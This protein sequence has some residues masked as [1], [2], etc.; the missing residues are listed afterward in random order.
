MRNLPG[1][2]VSRIVEVEDRVRNE[3]VKL[4]SENI[5]DS[6]CYCDARDLNT[7][8]SS[9]T[10][11]NTEDCVDSIH[12]RP[13]TKSHTKL[14]GEHIP[15]RV[16]IRND[17]ADTQSAGDFRRVETRRVK[18]FCVL[19]L[20]SRVNTD[21]LKTVLEQKRPHVR[22]M[23]VCPLRKNPRKVLLKLTLTANDQ[24]GFVL[25]NN[26]CPDYVKCKPWMPRDAQRNHPST[27]ATRWVAL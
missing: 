1:S 13:N 2:L 26:F 27:R 24:A 3:E 21:I 18:R 4:E 22:S 7:P 5:N 25:T 14:T 16:T 11:T 15:V 6:N 17:D 23:R 12:K 20:S 10:H 19:G 8:S 9:R